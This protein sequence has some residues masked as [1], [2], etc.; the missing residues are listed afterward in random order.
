LLSAAVDLSYEAGKRIRDVKAGKITGATEIKG[1]TD[2][3]VPEPKTLADGLSNAAYLNGLHSLWPQLRI[4]S[5]EDEP[6]PDDTPTPSKKGI[7]LDKEVYLNVSDTLVIV[8][9][10]DATKEFEED[11]TQYVT[12]MVCVAV[13][14]RPIAGIITTPMLDEKP[15]WAVV[16]QG[17]HDPRN[18]ENVMPPAVITHSRS[19]GKK[20]G[21]LV[22]Q[23]I[24][25]AFPGYEPQEAGGSGYKALLVLR[26]Q[27]AGYVHTSQI[28]NW[29]VC[30]AEA[31]LMAAHG[32]LTDLKG[33][34]LKY[35]TEHTTF[36][37]GLLGARMS[38]VHSW[39]LL[40]LKTFDNAEPSE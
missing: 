5:E 10:L 34:T 13:K 18:E 16:G 37:N 9:P 26:G 40:H 11:L 33:E 31:V 24:R 17:V 30:S 36:S 8:D 29:D 1:L 2:G 25:Q 38:D 32:H 6:L 19:H 3:G 14:G 23:L 39:L 28:H 4:L 15:V 20:D 35:D 21:V 27:A 7:T 12:T 22:S